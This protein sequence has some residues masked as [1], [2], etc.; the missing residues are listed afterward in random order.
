MRAELISIA[1]SELFVNVLYQSVC[2]P[3]L[4]T[5]GFSQQNKCKQCSNQRFG[6]G[7]HWVELAI[8]HMQ[9][10]L[11]PHFNVRSTTLSVSFSYKFSY[12]WNCQKPAHDHCAFS[13]S[14]F[15]DHM[16]SWTQTR[17]LSRLQCI[18]GM[19]IVG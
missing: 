8:L 17:A 13:I 16:Q 14:V 10:W 1:I 15:N 5:T 12:K 6:C 18:V 7:L 11:V 19:D 9:I 3:A 4:L 2:L